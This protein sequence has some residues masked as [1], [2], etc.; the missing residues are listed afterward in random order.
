MV[1]QK[2]EDFGNNIYWGHIS[3]KQAKNEQNII[4]KFISDLDKYKPKEESKKFLEMKL[5]IMQNTFLVE[6]KWS[7]R[8]LKTVLFHC[9]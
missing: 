8:H 1:S 4:E 7:L 3:I 2:K 6:E 5:L 9:L